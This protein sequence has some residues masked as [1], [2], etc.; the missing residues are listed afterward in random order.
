MKIVK[1][2]LSKLRK[3]YDFSYT[4]G[5]LLFSA[6]ITIILSISLLYLINYFND[7]N[8]FKLIADFS[9]FI[10]VV[11]PFLAVA[12]FILAVVNFVT[13]KFYFWI[14]KVPGKRNIINKSKLKNLKEIFEEERKKIS[15]VMV[16]NHIAQAKL[17]TKNLEIDLG[18]ASLTLEEEQQQ[19]L[20]KF[21][22]KYGKKRNQNTNLSSGSYEQDIAIVTGEPGASKSV[23]MQEL[24]QTL[25]LGVEN[26][27]HSFIPLFVLARDLTIQVLDEVLEENTPMPIFL[28]NYYKY[29]YRFGLGIEINKSNILEDLITQEWNNKDFFIIIDGLDEIPQRSNYEQIQIKLAEIIKRDI[30]RPLKGVVH[31]YIL[32]CRIDEDLDLFG[33]TEKIYLKGL[34]ENQQVSFCNALMK[35]YNKE[36][37]RKLENTLR[38]QAALI[39]AHV[40][41][42][43]P[44]FLTLLINYFEQGIQNQQQEKTI[45]FRVLMRHYLKRESWRSYANVQKQNHENIDL[46]EHKLIFGKLEIFSRIYLEWLAYYCSNLEKS[47]SLYDNIYLNKKLIKLFIRD[48]QINCGKINKP[49]IWYRINEFFAR[50]SDINFDEDKIFSDFS[51]YLVNYLGDDGIRLFC[52]LSKKLNDKNIFTKEILSETLGSIPYRGLE[53]EEW[54]RDF[55]EIFLQKIRHI[56]LN[57]KSRL[58]VLFLFRSIAASHALRILYVDLIPEKS[59]FFVRFRHRRLAE[60]YAAC[61]YTHQW[62]V[63]KGNLE[64]HPWLGPIFNL[65]CALEGSEC[66]ALSWLITQIDDTPTKP[67]YLWR[68]SVEIAVEAAH[69]SAPT[70]KHKKLVETL[71]QKIIH[72]LNRSTSAITIDAITTITILRSIERLLKL[73]RMLYKN[74]TINRVCINKFYEYESNI[75]AEWMPQVIGTTVVFAKLVD[76]PYPLINRLKSITKAVLYPSSILF[77][78]FNK[79]GNFSWHLWLIISIA[80]ISTVTGEL[81]FVISQ[82]FLI[83]LSLLVLTKIFLRDNFEY[84]ITTNLSISIVATV[85]IVV[86]IRRIYKWITNSTLASQN[87]TLFYRIINK[88]YI[89]FPRIIQIIFNLNFYNSIMNM[90]KGKFVFFLR[91]LFIRTSYLLNKVFVSFFTIVLPII[92]YCIITVLF[93]ALIFNGILFF[94]NLSLNLYNTNNFIKCLNV[95]LTATKIANNF[96]NKVKDLDNFNDFRIINNESRH[97]LDKVRKDNVSSQCTYKNSSQLSEAWLEDELSKID[98]RFIDPKI[99]KPKVL[100]MNEV[101]DL[102]SLMKSSSDDQSNSTKFSV[103]I[104]RR[105]KIINANQKLAIYKSRFQ[106][107]KDLDLPILNNNN[108]VTEEKT[109]SNDDYIK[110]ISKKIDSN[111]SSLKEINNQVVQLSLKYFSRII[112][113]FTLIYSSKILWKISVDKKKIKKI[114]ITCSTNVLFDYIL[115]DK[116]NESVRIAA[117]NRVSQLRINRNDLLEKVE[118]VVGTLHKSSFEIDKNLGIKLAGVARTLANRMRH[119]ISSDKISNL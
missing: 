97:K 93:I 103:V 32:S 83:V 9:V 64:Y 113:L 61:Y 119:S 112:T 86:T 76:K 105:D 18:D 56:D 25:S 71:L 24:H 10:T 50:L 82:A 29:R 11:P 77:Y 65:T 70:P 27:S 21:I 101:S 99:K 79:S 33:N 84:V 108:F 75:T 59:S 54:Y 62:N 91:L 80:R 107:A 16:P 1:I 110:I 42:R 104:R 117:I 48:F 8:L 66:N 4:K 20:K 12:G 35:K 53:T 37:R 39:P 22:K 46:D 28:S 14:F 41:R 43:N 115:D 72:I 15:S 23:L 89:I 30:S 36:H 96:T 5:S 19:K 87:S 78:D 74:I 118:H 55:S 92:F 52:N 63:I 94:Y 68:Y 73:N 102:E 47:G 44:Y 7:E 98:K 51:K 116:Q 2:L 40:F 69:F 90:F 6:L 45:D 57:I 106:E 38:S 49:N 13:S 60:Y 34:S 95:N 81:L 111:N 67:Y 17:S 3:I 58:I 88:Y 109:S 114:Q 85:I 26:G 100:T 31:R